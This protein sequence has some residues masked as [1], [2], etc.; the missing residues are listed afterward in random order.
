VNLTGR[1]LW[2]KIVVAASCVIIIS[3]VIV[4]VVS[5]GHRFSLGTCGPDTIPMSFSTDIEPEYDLSFLHEF[6]EPEPD[7]ILTLPPMMDYEVRQQISNTLLER[8]KI[9]PAPDS[10]IGLYEFPDTRLLLVSRNGA[11]V[12]LLVTGEKI[13][14]FNLTPVFIGSRPNG[15][16]SINPVQSGSYNLSSESSIAIERIDLVLPL[17]GNGTAPLYIVNKT[18]IDRI[19][20]PDGRHLA[21]ITSRSTFYVRYGQRVERIIGTADV[22]LDPAWKQCSSQRRIPGEGGRRGDIQHTEKFA[23]GPDRIVWSRLIVMS[24]DIQWHDTGDESTSVWIST[25][26]TGCSC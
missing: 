20:Y 17:P 14:T 9:L 8:A 22:R 11:F 7:R 5:P 16:T 24:S 19:L 18:D 3:W 4:L 21:S 23:R 10:V 6:G 26:S 15:N 12:E 13:Q 2:E 25:D 1:R